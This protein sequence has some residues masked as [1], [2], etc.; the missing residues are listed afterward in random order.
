MQM[1]ISFIY[2]TKYVKSRKGDNMDLQNKLLVLSK[3]ANA[4][5]LAK[6][7]WSIGASAMLYFM[8][9][10][11]AFND[12][13]IMLDEEDVVKAKAA[14]KNFAEL[15][16]PN[17]SNNCKSKVFL[18][19]IIEDVEVDIMAGLTIDYE[20]E[21]HYFPLKHEHITKK[22]KLNDEVIPLHSITEWKR[23]Y[24]LMG[25]DIKVQLINGFL[26]ERENAK[27]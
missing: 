26:K 8:G 6:V 15:K 20:G 25:R 13:D 19:Y 5:N 4:L 24:A 3:V 7:N 23:Y 1:N 18:E 9:A 14:L 27:T 11:T 2:A 12:I 17:S 21:E 16:E 10:V 22:I